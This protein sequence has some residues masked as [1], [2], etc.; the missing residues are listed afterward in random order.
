MAHELD[1]NAMPP[2]EPDEV[3]DHGESLDVE[4]L[5][6]PDEHIDAVV[7]FA[8]GTDPDAWTELFG[9]A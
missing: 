9:N 2:S 6:V 7:L 8:D 4:D 3:T 5:R 1:A